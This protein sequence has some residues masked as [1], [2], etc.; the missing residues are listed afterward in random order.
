ML[1]IKDDVDLKY[2]M[3]KFSLRYAN[4]CDEPRTIHIL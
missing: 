1:K 3:Y 2:L 4:H